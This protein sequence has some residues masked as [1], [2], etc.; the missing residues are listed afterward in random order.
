MLSC[1]MTEDLVE[2]ETSVQSSVS[3]G[4][5]RADTLYSQDEDDVCQR[6]DYGSP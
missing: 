2:T 5:A 6:E 4:T 3:S 1:T